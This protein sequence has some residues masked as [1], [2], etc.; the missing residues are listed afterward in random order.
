[1][2][3]KIEHV[4]RKVETAVIEA[5]QDFLKLESSGGILLVMAAVLAM[6]LKNSFLA[7]NYDALLATPVAIR[8]GGFEIFKPLLL[9]INDGLMAIFFFL[10][11]LEL[12][13]EV[14][15]GE[16]SRPAQVVLPLSGAIGGMAVPALIYAWLNHHDAVALNGWAIPSATDIAFALGVLLLL[17]KRVPASLKIFLM[18]LAILDDLGAIVIIA[19]FYTSDLSL[20]SLAVAGSALVVLLY[21]NR[22]GVMS[23]PAYVLVGMVMWASVLKSGVHATLAG[24]ALAWFIP[25]R[26]PQDAQ[27]SPLRVL[28]HDLHPPVA[29]VILPL[30]AFANAGLSLK[31][32]D[33]A[34]ILAPVTLGVAAGLFVGKQLGVFGGAW[35]VNR[36][37]LAK[38]PNGM[39]WSALYGVALLAGIGFTMSLFIGSLAFE[40]EGAEHLTDVRLGILVGSIVSALA[41]YAVLRFSLRRQPG[42]AEVPAVEESSR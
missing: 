18:T 25:L 19:I 28:E 29:Y 14:L 34:T 32:I 10:V 26:N 39:S 2:K 7:D 31:G 23:I 22:R 24:V 8:I 33:L 6:I 5:V 12:K 41:G 17:G 21:M 4:T 36:L 3:R 15:E 37:G 40:H 16:L 30:F 42:E 35:I 27:H 20:V 11:G 13:R 9:W 1:M 38:L